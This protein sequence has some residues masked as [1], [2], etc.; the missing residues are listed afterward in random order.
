RIGALCTQA[1]L[2]RDP[3]VRTWAGAVAQAASRMASPQ[4]RN[5]GTLGGNL[6][7][8]SPAGDLIPPLV[9]L[10]AELQLLSPTG[11]RSLPVYDFSTGVKRTVLCEGEVVGWVEIPL[12][13]GRHSAFGKIG[14]RRAVAVSKVS[15]AVAAKGSGR[16]LSDVRVALGAVAPTVIRSPSAEEILEGAEPDEKTLE[17]AGRGAASDATPIDD[18]RSS[19]EYRNRI[20][21]VLLRRVV[22]S[23]LQRDEV[24]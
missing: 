11:E 22:E 20:V 19:A 24:S 9:A 10:D 5:R 16:A 3:L 13:E 7:T 12:E 14:P 2:A 21:A 1:E 6:G 18:F 23:L 4:V 8:A 15:V 17:A